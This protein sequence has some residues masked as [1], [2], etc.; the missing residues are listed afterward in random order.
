MAFY[1]EKLPK[2]IKKYIEDD[3][4]DEHFD[5][6]RKFHTFILHVHTGVFLEVKAARELVPENMW[7][8]YDS[9]GTEGLQEQRIFDEAMTKFKKTFQERYVQNAQVPEKSAS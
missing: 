9:L 5:E 1:I 2:K 6:L 7:K 8:M 3:L 4:A